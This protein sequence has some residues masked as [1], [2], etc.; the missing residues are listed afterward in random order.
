MVQKLISKRLKMLNVSI[1]ELMILFSSVLVIFMLLTDILGWTQLF[2]WL[3][4][5]CRFPSFSF[6]Y[7]DHNGPHMWKTLCSANNGSN[8]SPINIAT[9]FVVVQSS[10]PLQWTGYNKG[11]LSMTIMNNGYNVIVNAMWNA[12]AQPYI[13]GGP[14]TSTYNFHSMVFHWGQSN[15]E[16]SEHTIDYVRYPMELQVYHLR[17]DFKSPM[18]AIA[19]EAYNS[20][21]VVSFLFQITNADNP[22]LDHIITNLW[23]I[24][25]PGKKV[26][27]S[28]FPLE[29][30][31]SPFEKNYYT[32]GGSLTQPPCSEIVTWILHPEPIAVSSFQVAQFRS[33]C[34]ANGPILLN[35]RP[36]QRINNR[37]IYFYE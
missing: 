22:Y 20:M 25:Q 1:S 21:L 31:F 5:G 28:P 32:Y 9:Q 17:H 2:S 3:E 34:S 27:I 14:L 35:C 23:R 29:W 15:E 19:I 24:Q 12:L 30:F 8:Q 26:H 4:N 11:P 7:S 33:L 6:G 13:R 18:D 36:V 10:E 37:N 16:G